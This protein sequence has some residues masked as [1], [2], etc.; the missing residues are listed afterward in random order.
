[1][2]ESDGAVLVRNELQWELSAEK[3]MLAQKWAIG[4]ANAVAKPI[5]IQSQILDSMVH[6]EEPDRREM[7]E[8]STVVLEG[9]DSLMLCHET[10]IGKYPIQAMN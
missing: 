2:E 6:S 7:T 4:Q 3:L 1:M 8:V 9:C 5:I 10:S